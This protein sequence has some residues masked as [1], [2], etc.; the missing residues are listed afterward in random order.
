[1]ELQEA[2]EAPRFA[3]YAAP[4]SFAP[5]E[6][7]P[8]RLAIEAR[9]PAAVRAELAR[10]GHGVVEWPESTWLAGSVEAVLTLPERGL[11]A[12]GADTRRP[13][14]AIAG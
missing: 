3:S 14:H 1:M 4:S 7:F 12:A 10:R 5:F 11:V 8:G 9:V 6:A 2:I 13:A